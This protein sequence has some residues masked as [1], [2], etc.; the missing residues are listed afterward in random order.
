MEIVYAF[1]AFL[2]GVL[3]LKLWHSIQ[4]QRELRFKNRNLR[5]R[6]DR[7]EAELSYNV[8]G[9]GEAGTQFRFYEKQH[10]AKTPPDIEKARTNT[11]WAERCERHAESIVKV[12]QDG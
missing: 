7:L 5:D 12:M 3:G 10:L 9:F 1:Y 6:I 4:V 2:V 11:Q 8:V